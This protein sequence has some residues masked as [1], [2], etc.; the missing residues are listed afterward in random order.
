MVSDW[1]LMPNG[2]RKGEEIDSNGTVRQIDSHI[3]SH[4]DSQ[5][6]RQTD[7]QKQTDGQ[8]YASVCMT[9]R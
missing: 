8:S 2:R 1:T 9:Q 5:T 3:D 6:D 7:R 4:I